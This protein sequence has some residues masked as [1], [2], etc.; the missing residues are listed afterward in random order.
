MDALCS[1]GSRRICSR[2]RE[3]LVVC[4]VAVLAT[5][6]TTSPSLDE[7]PVPAPRQVVLFAARTDNDQTRQAAEAWYGDI[8]VY[9]GDQPSSEAI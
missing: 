7:S 2:L 6:C 1:T 5:A 4:T 9:C 3:F 8:V